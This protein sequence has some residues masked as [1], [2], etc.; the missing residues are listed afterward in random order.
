VPAGRASGDPPASATTAR[1]RQRA[2]TRSRPTAAQRVTQA[3]AKTPTATSAEIAARLKV[4]E[5]TVQ[6]YRPGPPA[7]TP[8]AGNGATAGTSRAGVAPVPAAAFARP[9]TPERTDRAGAGT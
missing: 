6:R 4:S 7:A 1:P 5:R 9:A 2:A 3:A 8:V